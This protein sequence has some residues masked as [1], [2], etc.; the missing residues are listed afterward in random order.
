MDGNRKL[1]KKPIN[2]SNT[3]DI[4]CCFSNFPVNPMINATMIISAARNIIRGMMYVFPLLMFMI[5]A[6][7]FKL[8]FNT[9]QITNPIKSTVPN[10]I[11]IIAIHIAN[12]KS[13]I[14][15]ACFQVILF[16]VT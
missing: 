15:K 7:A 10:N 6:D 16:F 5:S 8:S 12:I 3:I 9:I 13:H 11:S 1:R 2:K 14:I 4:A